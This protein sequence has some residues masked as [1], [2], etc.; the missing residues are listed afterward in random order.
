M[1]DFKAKMHQIRLGRK[2]WE[3][4]EGN[5][6]GGEGRKVV[7]F[8]SWLNLGYAITNSRAPVS[9]IL[10]TPRTVFVVPQFNST[11]PVT[12][13]KRPLA[14]SYNYVAVHSATD[15]LTI[16]YVQ[17]NLQP[18]SVK[19]VFNLKM[20]LNAF[21]G[22]AAGAYSSPTNPLL[23]LKG[24]VSGQI[25]GRGRR[26]EERIGRM[27]ITPPSWLQHWRLHQQQTVMHYQLL[28]Y[29]TIQ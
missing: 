23:D 9:S 1:S 22:H 2:E 7:D 15:S 20:H 11:H 21:I 29:N 13:W 24:Y 8:A 4:E 28:Q 10:F 26:G 18:Y 6:K 12:D 14:A 5:G 19:C 25:M 16:V 3:K 17:L 27:R